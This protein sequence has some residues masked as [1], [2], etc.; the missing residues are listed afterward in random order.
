L[1]EY[2]RYLADRND[3]RLIVSDDGRIMTD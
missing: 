3:G 2:T 1:G